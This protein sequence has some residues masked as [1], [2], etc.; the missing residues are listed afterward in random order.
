[1]TNKMGANLFGYQST[2]FCQIT[3]L[4]CLNYLKL[5]N[6]PE[7]LR[8]VAKHQCPNGPKSQKDKTTLR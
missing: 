5:Q 1:M 6:Y 7:T 2:F 4:I 8:K 3:T